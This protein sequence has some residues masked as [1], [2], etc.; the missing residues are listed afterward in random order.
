MKAIGLLSGGLDSTLAVRMI[1]DQG[2]E[3]IAVKFTSPFCQC[4]SGGCC[5]AAEQACRM[6]IPLKT[7][8]KG[9]DYLEVVRTAGGPA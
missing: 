3:V 7:F 6:G 5:H 9:D 1:V 2:I 8:A 4:D